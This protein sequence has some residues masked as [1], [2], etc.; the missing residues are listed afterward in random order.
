MRWFH[1]L[2]SF[3]S[4]ALVALA[5]ASFLSESGCFDCPA[6]PA[7]MQALWISPSGHT[8]AVGYSGVMLES[9]DDATWSVLRKGSFDSER[10]YNGVWG[11]SET[12]FYV[13]GTEGT[14]LH[15]TDGKSFSHESSGTTSELQAVW[16]SG[17]GDVYAVGDAGTILHSTGNGVWTRQSNLGDRLV[18]VWGSSATDVFAVADGGESGGESG[19]ASGTIF[20]SKGDGVWVAQQTTTS[21]TLGAV[22]GSGSADVYV[23]GSAG[24]LHF[25]GS[26][27]T[28]NRPAFGASAEE[29]LDDVPSWGIWGRSAD[30][31]FVVGRDLGGALILHGSAA[32]G[33]Q[34][35]KAVDPEMEL[36]AVA[37]SAT[38]VLIVGA[39]GVVLQSSG[40]G[41]WSSLVSRS[42]LVSA[43]GCG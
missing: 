36:H 34:T 7:D 26:A 32:G 17:A 30:D 35:E 14:I 23:A 15:S 31:V 1:L 38:S 3:C 5:G 9:F 13:V 42:P 18:A 20:H 27:W 10:D 16:G 33:W 29:T 2:R 22:W 25:D 43:R 40:N 11:S 24:I 21:G 37:G 41:A 4:A 39:R 19:V 12:D 8:I 28:V 6:I